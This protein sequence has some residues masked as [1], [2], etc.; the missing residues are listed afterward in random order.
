MKI[1]DGVRM[2]VKVKTPLEA[3]DITKK[4]MQALLN[5][6]SVIKIDSKLK[7][8]HLRNVTIHGFNFKKGIKNKEKGYMHLVGAEIQVRVDPEPGV[9]K[10]EIE[11]LDHS[12]YEFKRNI[13][14][15][16]KPEKLKKIRERVVADEAYR[17]KVANDFF[18]TLGKLYIKVSKFKKSGH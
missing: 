3:F 8:P 15:L 17:R 7:V 12:L 4:I 9:V 5:N 10:K 6:T 13:E 14:G 2:A 16:N 1:N 18:F 11:T